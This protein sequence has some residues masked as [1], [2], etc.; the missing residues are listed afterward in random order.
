MRKSLITTAM[1]ACGLS[2]VAALQ[3]GGSPAGPAPENAAEPTRPNVLLIVL[4]DA[5]VAGTLDMLRD[6]RSRIVG[7]A[8]VDYRKSYV[9]I[10]SCCPERGSLLTGQFPHNTG[11]LRQA[12]GATLDKTRT[13]PADLHRAGYRTYHVGKLLHEPVDTDPPTGVFHRWLIGGRQAG[14]VDPVVNL[15]GTV[16]QIPGYTTTIIGD[17]ARRFLA[18][19][20]ARGDAQPWYLSL[21]SRLRTRRPGPSRA[22]P[23]CRC[24]R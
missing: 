13:V 6:S 20:E 9:A 16:Q 2:L 24:R 19:A 7:S 3:V 18:S 14:Y 22:T 4:D 17:Y 12:L 5:T 23:R 8:G 1:L 15:D 10:P 11:V 21:N